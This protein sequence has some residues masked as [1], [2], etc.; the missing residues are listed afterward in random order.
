[1]WQEILVGLI[2]SLAVVFV[3]YRFLRNFW[4]GSSQQ[5][6]CSCNCATPCSERKNCSVAPDLNHSDT[7]VK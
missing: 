7:F 4:S 3:A 2:V 1:M 5:P 6:G